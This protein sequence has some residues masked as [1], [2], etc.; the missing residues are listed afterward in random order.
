MYNGSWQG[1]LSSRGRKN[2]DASI[3]TFIGDNMSIYSGRCADS[4]EKSAFDF[5]PLLYTRR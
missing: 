1:G 2:P 5:S 3:Y 4:R